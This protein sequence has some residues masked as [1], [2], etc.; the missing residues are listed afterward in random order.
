MNH[1]RDYNIPNE[2]L[3]LVNILNDMYNDNTLQINNLTQSINLLNESNIQIRS[4]LTQL[5]YS[6][7]R[8]STRFNHTTIPNSRIN[9]RE[10]INMN[11]NRNN[12]PDFFSRL[13]DGFLQPVVVFPTQS[14]IESATRITRYGDITSPINRSCPISLENFNE[15][16]MV[17]M[18]R[19]CG[20][21]FNSDE[22][23]RW[24]TTNC[25]C[26][27]CR[28]DIRNFNATVSSEFYATNANRQN[29]SEGDG[30]GQEGQEQ[31]GQEQEGQEQEGQTNTNTVQFDI[32]VDNYTTDI[33]GNRP[34][35]TFMTLLN[36]LQQPSR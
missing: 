2:H 25:R 9:Y 34:P 24:F 26:P 30:E 1:S 15:E 6:S 36:A 19:F 12:R 27:V 33:S 11:M 16:D 17:T 3:L 7:S 18:I 31:E 32:I 4:L 23:N 14:H 22:L 20:H 8:R 35:Y 29:E 10:N 28:Y 13:L 21:I 5:L